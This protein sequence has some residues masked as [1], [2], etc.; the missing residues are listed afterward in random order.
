MDLF[1]S[2]EEDYHQRVLVY[3]SSLPDLLKAKPG[4]KVFAW[5]HEL[6]LHDAGRNGG[7]GK[8]DLLSVDEEGSVWLIE[9]KFDRTFELGQ[10]VWD[11]QLRRYKEAI[12][13]MNWTE[14][15]PYVAKFLRGKEKTRPSVI[16]PSSAI[17]LTD[18]L[19]A[20]QDT[21]GSHALPPQELSDRIA[22]ALKDGTYGIMVITDFY[23]GS[24]S[25]Y[26]RAFLHDG[27][28]AYVQGVPKVSGVAFHLRWHRE[29]RRGP[30]RI[31][32][33]LPSLLE[34]TQLVCHPD[35]FG[36]SLSEGTRE[37]WIDTIRPR[38][39]ALGGICIGSKGMG[40]EVVFRISGKSWP[41]LL[42]G[43]PERDAKN[44]SRE[45]KIAG[46]AAIRINPHIKRIFF[47]S[48]ENIELTNEAI[49]NFYRRGW[50]GRP[51]AN[52]RARWGVVPTSPEELRSKI[53]G[54]MQF[55]PDVATRD[56]TGRVGDRQS[57][58]GFLADF[59]ML[60][61]KLSAARL[62]AEQSLDR[63][64]AIK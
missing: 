37:L 4:L 29:A 44:I 50:R 42:I 43:W 10:F 32:E 53:Q 26:G 61:Q 34:R 13:R 11:C 21:I 28:L 48:G 22:S 9:L 6:D 24:Y 47:A 12:E 57:I 18:V 23:D 39:D 63:I 33:A 30:Q 17:T 54:I 55:E 36:D 16:S 60:L 31:F 35:T 56:H 40:F 64:S 41:L 51:A 46:T 2:N 7:N 20:W 49:G 45:E 1:C 52:M 38:I 27:P 5:A 15:L 3:L 14:I 62:H 19:G 58:D 25:T 8:A 59:S